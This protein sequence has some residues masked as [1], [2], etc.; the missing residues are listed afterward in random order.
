[1]AARL[2][3]SA[4]PGDEVAVATLSQAA[5]TLDA[6]DPGA[7]ADLSQRALDL[8]PRDHPMRGALVAKTAAPACRAARGD[9]AKGFADTVLRQSLPA[10]E[11]ADFRLIIAAMFT[12]SPDMRA[13]SCHQGLALP[14]IPAGWT[15][16]T[17]WCTRRR[18]QLRDL[19]IR[20][21]NSSLSWPNPV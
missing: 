7:A 8:A 16:R 2:A 6:T 20:A 4:E 11:E 17:R 18:R 12:L 9:E 21:V 5:D 15:K 3:A 13:D 10:E 1:V 19:E 14:D